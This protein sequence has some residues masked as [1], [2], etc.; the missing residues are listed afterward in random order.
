[1]FSKILF[2]FFLFFQ[3]NLLTAQNIQK[4][5]I[6]IA[7]G[8]QYSTLDI[9][10]NS[11]IQ[12]VLDSNT[13]EVKKTAKSYEIAKI[14]EGKIILKEDNQFIN[15]HYFNLTNETVWLQIEMN[16]TQ[17]KKFVSL[18]LAQKSRGNKELAILY[19]TKEAIKKYNNLKTITSMTK[20]EYIQLLKTY[21]ATNTAKT[22]EKARSLGIVSALYYNE[23]LTQILLKQGFNPFSERNA[24]G[25]PFLEDTEVKEILKTIK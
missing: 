20:A 10:A 1:M 11:I 14:I 25:K 13:L 15:I 16:G 2:S 19:R 22:K 6:V 12:K 5:W 17:I 8:N 23:L 9:Q 21:K 4:A 18:E 24:L 7:Y 3:T